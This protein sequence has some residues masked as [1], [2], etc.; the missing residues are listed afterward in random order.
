[1]QLIGLR[2]V[3]LKLFLQLEPFHFLH[4]FKLVLKD[5]ELLFFVGLDFFYQLLQLLIGLNWWLLD[6]WL[7]LQFLNFGIMSS[8]Q[9]LNFLSIHYF[10]LFSFFFQFLGIFCEFFT[11]D[12]WLQ[13]WYFLLKLHVWGHVWSFLI[14]GF[15]SFLQLTVFF[16]I[17]VVNLLLFV[18]QLLLHL[19]LYFFFL[20]LVKFF[21]FFPVL[22]RFLFKLLLLFLLDL[23][24]KHSDFIFSFFLL[25]LLLLRHFFYVLSLLGFNLLFE[26]CP[27]FLLLCLVLFFNLLLLWL[28]FL[29]YSGFFVF[30]LFALLLLKP[31]LLLFSLHLDQRIDDWFRLTHFQW[32]GFRSDA[33]N[34]LERIWWL[35]YRKFRAS[36]L[37]LLDHHLSIIIITWMLK[38]YLTSPR[39]RI[40]DFSIL[41][42]CLF[43]VWRQLRLKTLPG[44][45]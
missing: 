28:I 30:K 29:L 4:D 9:L 3:F 15:L 27:W 1:M 5:F 6:V 10:L 7:I 41:S 35:L 18:L 12:F 34:R 44:N 36:F 42:F 13:S 37:P 16:F 26:S 22:L 8:L 43:P 20:L 40:C 2:F 25:F 33:A 32:L 31:F 14:D 11:N 19:I 21:Q 45:P 23:L 39:I 17:N 38:H 24:L